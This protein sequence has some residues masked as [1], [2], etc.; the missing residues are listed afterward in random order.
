MWLKCEKVVKW[1]KLC[2]QPINMLLSLLLPID[3]LKLRFRSLTIWLLKDKCHNSYKQTACPMSKS[4]EIF[5]GLSLQFDKDYYGWW[6]LRHEFD[7]FTKKKWILRL[8][9]SETTSQSGFQ[10]NA[11]LWLARAF[12]WL[13]V[14][15]PFE[16]IQVRIQRK[17]RWREKITKL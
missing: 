11:G 7:W 6:R 8:S 1:V 10:S 5:Q 16:A 14:W 17:R 15:K 4:R 13:R 3:K 2:K 9:K 12:D